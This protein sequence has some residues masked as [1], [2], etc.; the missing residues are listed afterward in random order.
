MWYLIVSIPDL[1][2]ITYFCK[3]LIRASRFVHLQA[4][5]RLQH[6]VMVDFVNRW[7]CSIWLG[8]VSLIELAS[9]YLLNTDENWPFR[10]LALVKLS[11]YVIPSVTF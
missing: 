11:E 7:H 10:M 9:S 2:T 4:S 6:S 8:P 5:K 1:C 3:N